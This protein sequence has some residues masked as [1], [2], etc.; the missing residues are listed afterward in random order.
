VIAENCCN[1]FGR[2]NNTYIND[3]GWDNKGDYTGYTRRLQLNERQAHA[4][5]KYNY[6]LAQFNCTKYCT[7][8]GSMI[9]TNQ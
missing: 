9:Q 5:R 4:P 1:A 3:Y 8:S 7:E 2:V 6:H